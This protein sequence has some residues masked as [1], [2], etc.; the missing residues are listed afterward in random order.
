MCL[1]RQ[2]DQQDYQVVPWSFPLS[3]RQTTNSPWWTPY[4]LWGQCN[5]VLFAI[6]QKLKSNANTPVNRHGGTMLANFPNS[7]KRM[8]GTS[9]INRPSDG[10]DPSPKARDTICVQ[11]VAVSW[12]PAIR[13]A[14]RSWLRSSSIYEPS[15][16]LFRDFSFFPPS[17]A[18][19]RQAH[20]S[21]SFDSPTQIHE[22]IVQTASSL[23][24]PGQ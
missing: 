24:G 14:S 5:F 8:R 2:W 1:D 11:Q 9:T 10:Q 21:F 13:H 19:Y 22:L 6:Q 23:K 7:I 12:S 18:H 17:L 3:P 4:K 15:D 16:P 20:T